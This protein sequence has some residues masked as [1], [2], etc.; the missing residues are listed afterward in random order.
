MAQYDIAMRFRLSL[1]CGLFFM[2]PTLATAEIYRWVDSH[3]NIQ[4]GDRPPPRSAAKRIE[5]DINSYEGV[6]VK[7]FTAFKSTSPGRNSVVMYS[8]VWCGVC[9]RARQYFRA[10]KI[11]FREYDI[12]T[13]HKGKQDYV[14]LKGRGVPIILVGEKRMNGFSVSGFHRI[15]ESR[16]K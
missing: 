8:A 5:V 1:L 4:F 3:G 12:E 13:T 7:P 15:Y 14:R 2:L 6:T 11:P 16:R 9:K 10:Q